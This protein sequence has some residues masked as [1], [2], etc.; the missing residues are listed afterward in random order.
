MSSAAAHCCSLLALILVACSAESPQPVSPAPADTQS[1]SPVDPAP[2]DTPTAAASGE[3]APTATATATA[4]PTATPAPAG[5]G[6]I[7]KVELRFRDA[8]VPP[9]YH[10]SYTITLQAGSIRKAVDSYGTP[11][12]SA[13]AP[14]EKAELDKL[15]ADLGKLG[16]KDGAG[17]L[18]GCTGGTGYTLRAF[19]GGKKVLEASSE[20][21]GGKEAGP[22]VKARA[23]IQA[24][25]R[26]AP[27]A[28]GPKAAPSP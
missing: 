22:L 26:R 13:D 20:S 21:C 23:W 19:A 8:S 7:D 2:A 5:D 25:E 1:T 28:G 6:G 24:V 17:D 27:A 9:Q 15:L 18:A 16:L 12:S 3:V 4:A 11:I 14:L 10:R